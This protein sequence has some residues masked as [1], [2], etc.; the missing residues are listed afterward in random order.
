M[1]EDSGGGRLKPARLAVAILLSATGLT[2][3]TPATGLSQSCWNY[4]R[5]DRKMARKIN[6]ARSNQSR[7]KLRLDAE[8]SKVARVQAKRMADKNTLYHTKNLGSKVTN[9]T[10]VGENVG[11]GDSV[12]QLHSMFMNS[13]GHRANILRKSYR[14]VGV[15]TA[16]AGG[17]LWISV[18]FEARKNPGTTFGMPNC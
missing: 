15:G 8:L 13:S 3:L 5:A 4:K 11:Y 17:W 10:R 2:A 14:H 9:W 7:V 12:G 6:T 1:T 18:V 16:R